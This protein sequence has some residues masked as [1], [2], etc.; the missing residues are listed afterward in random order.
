[1]PSLG[2]SE[3]VQL[4][5][6]R[7]WNQA[8]ESAI[9]ELF[10]P[11]GIA[12]GLPGETLRSPK[13]FKAFARAFRAQ[14]PNV[15]IKVLRTVTEG[16]LCAAHCLVTGTALGRGG[17]RGKKIRFEGVTIVRVANGRIQEAWNT[18]DFLTFNQQIGALPKLPRS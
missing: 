16:E 7:V 2:P 3:V 10:A 17:A 14:V 5:F 18:F 9:D 1:M 11:R 8:D 4:W 15:R 12:H 6:E 13:A